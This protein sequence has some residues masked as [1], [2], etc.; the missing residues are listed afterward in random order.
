MT[1]DA[2]VVKEYRYTEDKPGETRAYFERL[3]A[4]GAPGLRVRIV[5]LRSTLASRMRPRR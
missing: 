4:D 3:P 5:G 1:L 2:K